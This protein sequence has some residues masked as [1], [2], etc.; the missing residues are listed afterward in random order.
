[1]LSA[2]EIK[3]VFFTI[4]S[5]A[6]LVIVPGVAISKVWAPSFFFHRSPDVQW[7]FLDFQSTVLQMGLSLPFYAAILPGS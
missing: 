2:L 3:K 5:C 7:T 4:A 6:I 1:M